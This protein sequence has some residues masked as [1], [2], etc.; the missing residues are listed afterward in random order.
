[1]SPSTPSICTSI[2]I[3]AYFVLALWGVKLLEFVMGWD[4]YWL[5][6]YPRQWDALPGIFSAPL[7]HGSW[8]HIMSNTLP[9]LLLGS[10]VIFGYPRSRWW[11]LSIVWLLSGLGVWL[12][13]RGSYHF[14]ASGLTHG[15]FFFLLL[16][17]LL[18]RDRR[19]AALLMIA[20]FMYSSMLL[21]IFPGEPGISFE[22]HL[23]GALSGLLCAYAFR[24]WDPKPQ[25]KAYPWERRAGEPDPLVEEDDPV[26]GDQWRL[27]TEED[28]DRKTPQSPPG[29]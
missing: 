25:R 24:H 8:Q 28:P 29:T 11:T 1:M 10:I 23:F 16:S 7:V 14:G 22:Y 26:I 18:R 4:L 19:S 20:F 13:G 21:G 15:M 3:A 5:G 17:G 2:H 27:T 6:V 9:T 12:F